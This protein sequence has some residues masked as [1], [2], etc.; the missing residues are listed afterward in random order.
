[1]VA[2]RRLKIKQLQIATGDGDI[3]NIATV[4]EEIIIAITVMVDAV[5]ETRLVEKGF[6]IFITRHAAAWLCFIIRK[7]A[8]VLIQ[9]F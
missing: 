2:K 1:M 6:K 7:R 9:A 8:Q 3:V 4:A 5:A